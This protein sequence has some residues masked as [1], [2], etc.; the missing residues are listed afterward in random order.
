[1]LL[2]QVALELRFL[3]SPVRIPLRDAGRLPERRELRLLGRERGIH[4][5]L[6]QRIAGDRRDPESAPERGLPLGLRLPVVERLLGGDTAG[7]DDAAEAA[8]K[9][10]FE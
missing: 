2:T 3:L 1:L 8:I 6:G 7:L 9:Q 10:F 5:R 4:A